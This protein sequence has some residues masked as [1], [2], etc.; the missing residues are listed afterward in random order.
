[1]FIG[2][3][4][5]G[6]FMASKNNKK[7]VNKDGVEIEMISKSKEKKAKT[8]P[9]F[10]TINKYFEELLYGSSGKLLFALKK[11]YPVVMT[12]LKSTRAEYIISK[13]VD[14]IHLI[15]T[16]YLLMVFFFWVCPVVKYIIDIHLLHR[17][18]ILVLGMF[19]SVLNA[20]FTILIIYT[21]LLI[22]KEKNQN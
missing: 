4:E 17:E 14:L 8:F 2:V 22:F 19:S 13:I 9:F 18:C 21:Y 6:I 10:K 1:M 20:I 15:E 16:I 12:M 11:E 3:S 7:W 5:Q